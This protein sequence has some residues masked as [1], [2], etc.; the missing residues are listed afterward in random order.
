MKVVRKSKEK[1]Q[2]LLKGQ[3]VEKY[4][5]IL[6]SEVQLKAQKEKYKERIVSKTEQF[7]SELSKKDNVNY[8][9]VIINDALRMTVKNQYKMINASEK[10]LLKES[11]GGKIDEYFKEELKV[12]LHS[13]VTEKDLDSIRKKIGQDVFDKIFKIEKLLKPTEVFDNMLNTDAETL[14]Q[15]LPLIEGKVIARHLP[16]LVEAE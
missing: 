16:T 2:V 6:T 14:S 8:Q 12:S 1:L 4:I 3:S 7:R 5:K 13:N 11:F 9:N 15:A 10:E